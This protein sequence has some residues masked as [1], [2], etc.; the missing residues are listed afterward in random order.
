MKQRTHKIIVE[1][2]NEPTVITQMDMVR[3]NKEMDAVE[4]SPK[5]TPTKGKVKWPSHV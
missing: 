1:I 4:W 5:V 3:M 2:T